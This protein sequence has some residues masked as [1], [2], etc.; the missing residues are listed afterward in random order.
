MTDK[1]I[2]FLKERSPPTPCLVVDLDVIA[3]RFHGLA[4]YLPL[5]QIYYAVKANPAPQV[6][7]R[8][9]G[10]GAC[11][12][13]ASPAE[14]DL[15][16]GLGAAPER[17]SYGNTIKKRADIAYAYARGVRLFAFDSEAELDKLAD[18]APGALQTT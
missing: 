12:D 18:A 7:K 10:A 9:I 17:L 8:L 13:V 4:D 1:I 14:V 16:L 11:F 5:A 6:V 15:C 2:R 3:E